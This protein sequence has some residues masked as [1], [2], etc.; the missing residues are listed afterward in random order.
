MG[1]YILVKDKLFC[2]KTS[3]EVPWV[4]DYFNDKGKLACLS[5][6]FNVVIIKRSVAHCFNPPY[7]KVSRFKSA[8]VL[9]LY[10][11]YVFTLNKTLIKII[12]KL[13]F[14]FFNNLIHIKKVCRLNFK[15]IINALR[16][17]LGVKDSKLNHDYQYMIWL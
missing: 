3:G 1:N 12:V 5:V 14:A 4:I 10:V 11:Y 7:K 16:H 17:V 15:W 9:V 2:L 13:S 6:L 8:L